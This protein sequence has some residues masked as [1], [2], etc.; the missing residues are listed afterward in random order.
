MS[1][2]KVNLNLK[3]GVSLRKKQGKQH[4]PSFNGGISQSMLRAEINNHNT[5]ILKGVNVLRKNIGE[6]Q[7]ICL[8]AL[9][10]GLL[11][12]LFI[13]Y[14]PL[15]KS[16]KDTR[17]YSAWR[18][19]LSAVLAVAT[20]GLITI[21]FAKIIHNMT[22]NGWFGEECNKTPF[23]DDD[24]VLKE[25]KKLYPNKN[26]QELEKEL[27]LFKKQ[28]EENL[29]NSIRKDNTVYYDYVDAKHQKMKPEN[30]TKL[31]KETT[32]SLLKEENDQLLRCQNDKYKNRLDR[33]LFYSQ[34][35]DSARN[36]LTEMEE[37][38]NKTDDLN[39][40]DKLFKAKF[41]ELKGKKVDSHLIDMFTETQG[42]IPAGKEEI[43]AKINKMR[44]HVD[45][46][47]SGMTV[48][49]ITA[50]VKASVDKR[51]AIHK[52]AIEFLNKVTEAINSGKTADQ[53][54]Q[55]FEAAKKTD[56][57]FS[58]KDKS[59]IQEVATKLKALT[60]SHIDG[61]KRISLLL[62]ALAMLPVSCSLL[63]WIYPRFMDAVFPN[64]SSK[65][66]TNES[67]ELVDK[68]TGNGEVK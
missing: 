56:A 21:P 64:L 41:K 67:K 22:N 23:K 29:L 30:F 8:N 45:K 17:T 9:G 27:A 1:V 44:G 55:M 24:Y 26:K 2:E 31:L 58:L 7:D 62:V 68:A 6:F 42:R 38:V 16:D 60:K 66:H 40:L 37:I 18:Q 12:P 46:Y 63:N 4:N 32:A 49:Q 11:A 34:N 43:L 14:N 33:S 28:Q 3:N 52:N 15:S 61:T 13:K 20:Q 59:F 54:E 19:P 10:T 48:E 57:T 5:P 50:S 25:L 35:A 47:S 36:L 39:E 51:A 65:K 53:I